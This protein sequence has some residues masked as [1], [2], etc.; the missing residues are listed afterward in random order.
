[1]NVQRMLDTLWFYWN[2]HFKKDW[3]EI[4]VPLICSVDRQYI[5]CLIPTES[6]TLGQVEAYARKLSKQWIVHQ[7]TK[8][9]G[10]KNK[11]CF[12]VQIHLSGYTKRDDLLLLAEGI[13]EWIRS[14]FKMPYHVVTVHSVDE[15]KSR[16]E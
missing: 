15:A 4:V 7:T 14:E 8:P 9:L 1:M 10:S 16:V 3:A 5:G 6:F 11:A 2:Q 13:G 12:S